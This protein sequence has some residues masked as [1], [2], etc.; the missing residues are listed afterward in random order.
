MEARQ[1]YL[2]TA[3]DAR[4]ELGSHF[5]AHSNTNTPD[6]SVEFFIFAVRAP[7]LHVYEEGAQLQFLVVL[8]LQWDGTEPDLEGADGKRGLSDEVGIAEDVL[9]LSHEADQ[10]QLR[11]EDLKLTT[12]V[13]Y[14]V[15][16]IV[17]CL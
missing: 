1:V 6:S 10:S 14:R 8:V 17:L 15:E 2:D 9:V 4:S 11:I 16:T 7:Y 3:W 12:L 13:P 5:P